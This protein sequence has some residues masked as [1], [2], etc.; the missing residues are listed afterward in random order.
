M[1]RGVQDGKE[2]G[3]LEHERQDTGATALPMRRRAVNAA[4]AASPLLL[5]RSGASRAEPAIAAQPRKLTL[6]DVTPPVA[7]AEPLSAR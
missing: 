5:L 3:E 2:N 1:H 7:P 6:A 4:L